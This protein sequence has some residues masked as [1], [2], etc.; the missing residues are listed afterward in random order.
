MIDVIKQRASSHNL[1]RGLCLSLPFFDDRALKMR[2]YDFQV[3]PTGR[4]E[5]IPS[6]VVRAARQEQVKVAQNIDLS[7]STRKHLI[8]GIRALEQTFYQSV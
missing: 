5:F 6:F 8:L 4:I 2:T 1:N 7:P 3:I